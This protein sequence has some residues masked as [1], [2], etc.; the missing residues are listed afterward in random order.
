MSRRMRICQWRLRAMPADA[1]AARPRRLAR[2]GR[3]LLAACVAAV[4][5]AGQPLGAPGDEASPALAKYHER[6]DESIDRALAWLAHEQRDDG[7]WTESSQ[8]R[9]SSGIAGLCVMAFL[10]K[11]HT[12]GVGPYGEA[13][14]KGVDFL[15]ANQEPNGLLVRGREGHGAMYS[16]S[17]AALALSEVSGMVDAERQK[18]I[19]KA[20][21]AALRLILAA[22]QMP[23]DRNH[24]GG[25]RYNHDSRDSDIS[26]TSWAIMAL[27][28]ARNNGAAVPTEAIDRGL[29]YIMNCQVTRDGGFAYQ[30]GGGSG[31]G[32]TGTALLCLELCGRHRD[33]AA[34]MAGE[35]ILKNLPDQ[36][37]RGDHF[38]YAMYYCSQGMFQL[39]DEY[40]ERWATRM[41]EIMLRAQEKAGNWPQA[42]E[43]VGEGANYYTTAMAVLA[44]SVSYRQ[45]P[46]YQ[47]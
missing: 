47:R 36:Y 4:S 2:L 31:W 19:D 16:H 9:N 15:L 11:G 17:I 20:L 13:I 6:I 32:R 42:R 7:S 5:L 27:R 35:W 45:L 18:R 12:P 40:W 38:S 23:K 14:N 24:A 1:A 33:R 8:S 29:E 10:A 21:S 41:Y 44:M 30:P 39:G 26:C 37:G 46:I 28:S 22:Q 3:I 25:W 43:N 34:L